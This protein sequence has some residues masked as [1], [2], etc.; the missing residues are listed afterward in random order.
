[1]VTDSAEFAT[2]PLPIDPKS[3]GVRKRKHRLIP[4]AASKSTIE[5]KFPNQKEDM[6]KLLKDMRLSESSLRQCFEF[7]DK[8]NSLKSN[9]NIEN[10]EKKV[11][12]KAA[13]EVGSDDEGP[14]VNLLDLKVFFPARHCSFKSSTMTV[15]ER[16]WL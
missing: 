4:Q 9:Y 12:H 7:S 3:L 14:D 10:F 13:V 11:T 5:Y 16:M 6:D 1:M 15:P 2:Y 8:V